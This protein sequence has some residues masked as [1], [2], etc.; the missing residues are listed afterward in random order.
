MVLAQLV[1]HIALV[2]KK[3]ANHQAKQHY[4]PLHFHPHANKYI[5]PNGT[6]HTDPCGTAIREEQPHQQQ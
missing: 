4:H 5:H 6:Q 2:Y 1:Q 3:H